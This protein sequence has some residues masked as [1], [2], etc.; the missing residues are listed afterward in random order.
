MNTLESVDIS[1]LDN[2]ALSRYIVQ[3][4]DIAMKWINLRFRA[5]VFPMVILSFF[6][7]RIIHKVKQLG[8][9]INQ[10][11]FLAGL[12]YKTVEV[13]RALYRLAEQSLHGSMAYRRF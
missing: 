1:K 6:L 13:D 2:Q 4:V 3:T 11:D 10:Y 9:S 8:Q 12:D 5:Y 7:N